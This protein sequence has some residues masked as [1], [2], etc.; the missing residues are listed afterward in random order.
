MSHIEICEIYETLCRAPGSCIS[1]IDGSEGGKV[2]TW[3]KVGQKL[4]PKPLIYGP[5]SLTFFNP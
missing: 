5:Q 3:T 1:I 4:G 2:S